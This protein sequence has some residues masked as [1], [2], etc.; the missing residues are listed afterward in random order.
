[1]TVPA[2]TALAAMSAQPGAEHI[3]AALTVP[4][5]LREGELARRLAADPW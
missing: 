5:D 4:C 1:M 2:R 3:T